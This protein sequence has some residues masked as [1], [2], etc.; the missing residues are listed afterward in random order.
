MSESRRAWVRDPLPGVRAA[1]FFPWPH[2]AERGPSGPFPI[3]PRTRIPSRGLQLMTSS[4][5]DHLPEALLPNPI[6]LDIRASP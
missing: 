4:E 1:T 3:P 6:T 5:P 2:L